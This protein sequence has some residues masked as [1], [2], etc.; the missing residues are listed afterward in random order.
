MF[1]LAWDIKDLSDLIESGRK[2]KVECQ[3]I[4]D[5]LLDETEDWI[6]TNMTRQL[7]SLRG[8]LKSFVKSVTRYQRTA[9]THILVVMISPEERNHKP[10]A[11]PVQC[12]PYNGLKDMEARALT[13]EVIK[14][15]TDRGMKVAG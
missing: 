8:Q 15:M 2:I 7:T 6:T 11:L 5:K 13:D 9:A 4:K 1:R 14:Y 3:T 10:Y 12:I